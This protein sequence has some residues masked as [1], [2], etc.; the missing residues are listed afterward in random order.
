MTVLAIDPG[1]IESAFV[2]YDG[3]R[4]VKFGKWPN[5]SLLRHIQVGQE[6]DSER[7][8]IEVLKPRGMP[9]SWEEMQTQLWAGRF[10]QAWWDRQGGEKFGRWEPTPVFRMDV[11]LHLCGRS[12]AKDSNVRQA[13]I[14]RFGGKEK[15]IGRKKSPGV[16]YGVAA[17]VWQAL[18]IA[19]YFHDTQSAGGK[20]CVVRSVEDAEKKIR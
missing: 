2:L 1:N 8:A 9:T 10:Y 18:A 7:C 13:L 14:D 3:E 4:P 5:A 16:L 15:A 6:V 19:V 12:S 17:D 11:K 20:A